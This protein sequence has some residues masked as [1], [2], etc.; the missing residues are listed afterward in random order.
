MPCQSAGLIKT[1]EFKMD[2]ALIFAATAVTKTDAGLPALVPTVCD[3]ASLASVA[4]PSGIAG[5]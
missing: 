2:L 3:N 4:K 5:G 1:Q